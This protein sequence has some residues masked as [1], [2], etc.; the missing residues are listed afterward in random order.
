M[1]LTD[2]QK[3]LFREGVERVHA[4]HAKLY[5]YRRPTSV[6]WREQSGEEI[7][8]SL[9]ATMEREKNRVGLDR[10]DG[11]AWTGYTIVKP[12]GSCQVVT[13]TQFDALMQ[14]VT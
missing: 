8:A 11:P 7:T 13:K 14:M 2:L 12:D 1:H 10:A 5:G 4:H 9:A 6:E 3:K